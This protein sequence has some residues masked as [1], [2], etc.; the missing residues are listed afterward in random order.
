VKSSTAAPELNSPNTQVKE[1]AG[2]LANAPRDARNR[3]AVMAAAF[4]RTVSIRRRN[5]LKAI[6]PTE[7]RIA[8]EHGG[9]VILFAQF[10]LMPSARSLTRNGVP[11]RL[12]SRALDILIALVE[13]AGQVIS[14]A[15]L[16]AIVW[17]NTFIV[18]SNLRGQ[19]LALRQALGDGQSGARF[20][21]SV[22][23]RG[24]T[25]VAR[26]E[27]MSGNDDIFGPA[28][29]AVANHPDQMP[30]SLVEISGPDEI[31]GEIV[32]R[33]LRE[34][35]ITVRLGLSKYDGEDTCNPSHRVSQPRLS[36]SLE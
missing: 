20:I 6:S 17:P 5:M 29:S 15:E 2:H 27:L 14:N 9:E 26:T 10:R 8:A 16:L 30:S 7:R 23:G 31:V 18:E 21:V 36:I 13:R 3:A 32:G 24:Y 12:G 19:I 25:F 33:L 22:R 4:A 1:I 11:V 28:L 34:R 35:F